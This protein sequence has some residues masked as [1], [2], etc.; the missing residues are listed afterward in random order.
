MTPKSCC[1]RSCAITGVAAPTISKN[2]TAK[3]KA[4]RALKAFCQTDRISASP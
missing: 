2:V 3:P 1:W 4:C